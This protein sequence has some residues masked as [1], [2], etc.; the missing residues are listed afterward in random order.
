MQGKV[1]P[2]DIKAVTTGKLPLKWLFSKQHRA[3]DAK[4]ELRADLARRGVNLEG[5]QQTKTKIPLEFFARGLG[6][7]PT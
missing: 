3:F 2:E 6:G 7:P 1:G 4:A 5:E